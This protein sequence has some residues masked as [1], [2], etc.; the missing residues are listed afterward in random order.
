MKSVLALIT[1]GTIVASLASAST[2]SSLTHTVG[3]GFTISGI[4]QSS[5]KFTDLVPAATMSVTFS[6][7]TSGGCTLASF[8]NPSGYVGCN[9]A[10]SFNLVLS[11]PNSQTNSAGWTITNLSGTG[12]PSILTITIDLNPDTAASGFIVGFDNGSV[13]TRSGGA[14]LSGSA[15]L[16]DALHTSGQAAAS[17]T[18]YGKLVL[19]FDSG[20]FNNGLTFTFNAA[21]H[22][23]NGPVIVDVPEPASYTMIGLGLALLSFV[24]ARR[25]R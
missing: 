12:G 5:V 20:T 9:V 15:L 11:P 10:N 3:Q 23:I 13:Q 17:A 1:F 16:T 8:P 18:Q 22:F 21:N 24:Q 7:S 14:S 4:G 6:D 19:S 2:I 25:R